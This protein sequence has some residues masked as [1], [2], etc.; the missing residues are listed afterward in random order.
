M[1]FLRSRS[2][3]AAA[4][5]AAALNLPGCAPA[6]TPPAA[7]AAGPAGLAGPTGPAEPEEVAD[8]APVPTQPTGAPAL[9]PAPAPV[10]YV[11]APVAA[12]PVAPVAATPDPTWPSVPYSDFMAATQDQARRQAFWSLF[13]AAEREAHQFPTSPARWVPLRR[14]IDLPPGGA[15]GEW[16]T[17]GTIELKPDHNV[18]TMFHEIFHT[19]V[20]LSEFHTGGRDG[21]WTEALCDAF[22]YAAEQELLPGPPSKWEERITRYTTMTEQEVMGTGKSSSVKQKYHYPAS[23]IVKRSGGTMAGFRS[24]WFQLIALKQQRGTEVL[25]DFF[26]YRPPQHT[27]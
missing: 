5:L 16:T 21:A 24:L 8:T 2:G 14:V 15:T 7:T 17:S 18:G 3:L 27:R 10:A 9:A 20:H 13:R 1:T 19:V 23:L 12:M 11:A 4:A 25:D 26:G 22:R 6:E